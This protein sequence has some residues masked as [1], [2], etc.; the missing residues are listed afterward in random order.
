M[1]TDRAQQML[2]TS[3]IFRNYAIAAIGVVWTGA[4]LYILL[5]PADTLP[6][7]RDTRGGIPVL[8][9]NFDSIATFKPLCESIARGE[10]QQTK[11]YEQIEAAGYDIDALCAR[12]HAIE[13][14]GKNLTPEPG[15]P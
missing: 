5:S 12:V 7:V 3:T 11:V 9:L 10:Q 4:M 6:P 2:L 8:S 13:Q 15:K 14:L 1:K